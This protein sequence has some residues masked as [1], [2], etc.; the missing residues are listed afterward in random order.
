MLGKV[1][2]EGSNQPRFERIAFFLQIMQNTTEGKDVMEDDAVGHEVIVLDDLPLLIAV[3][4]GDCSVPNKSQAGL[5]NKYFL[6][7]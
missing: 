5:S 6:C 7:D 4:G 3:I 1:R 2:T